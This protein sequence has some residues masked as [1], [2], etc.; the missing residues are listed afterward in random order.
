MRVG[1]TDTS[2]NVSRV[3]EIDGGACFG[4]TEVLFGNILSNSGCGKYP[5]IDTSSIVDSD[6]NNDIKKETLDAFK[7]YMDKETYYCETLIIHSKRTAENTDFK[8][9]DMDTPSGSFEQFIS[10]IVNNTDNTD[11]TVKCFGE[12]ITDMTPDTINIVYRTKEELSKAFNRLAVTGYLDTSNAAVIVNE[13][14]DLSV[15]EKYDKYIEA[16]L[17]D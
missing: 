16:Y 6:Y 2:G 10:D 8:L 4:A 11:E 12:L 3:V 1:L 9:V 14:S 13:Y 17:L 5:K 15:K 7:E